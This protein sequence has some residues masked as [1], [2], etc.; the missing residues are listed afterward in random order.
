L[1]PLLDPVDK[2]VDKLVKIRPDDAHL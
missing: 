2:S 1:T